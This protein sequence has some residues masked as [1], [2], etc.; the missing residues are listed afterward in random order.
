MDLTAHRQHNHIIS[1]AD[2]SLQH[3]IFEFAFE[4]VGGADAA[5]GGKRT[6]EHRAA[7]GHFAA[8]KAAPDQ[9]IDRQ[10]RV[11]RALLIQ[12]APAA[13]PGV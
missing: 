3:G 8:G 2:C 6:A 5:F 10:D 7:V 13:D 9:F 12:L 4:A 11:K 1:V